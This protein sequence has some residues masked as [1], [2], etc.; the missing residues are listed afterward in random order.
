M[1]QVYKDKEE[2]IYYFKTDGFKEFLRIA[3]YN[4]GRTNLREQLLIYGCKEGEIVYTTTK[5]ET[6]LIKCWLKPG[7]EQ[8]DAMVEFFDDV[9]DKDFQTIENNPLNKEDKNTPT[10][11]DEKKF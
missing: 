2:K 1:R 10:N 11:I 6:K 5:G 3:R 4:L 8:L 7:D 9:L